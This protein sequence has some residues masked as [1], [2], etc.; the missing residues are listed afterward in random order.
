MKLPKSLT[1]V[2]PFS[3]ACALVLLII[4]PIIAFYLGQYCQQ[5]IDAARFG[6]SIIK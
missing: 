1:T 2:T 3:A 4:I 6:I 5:M